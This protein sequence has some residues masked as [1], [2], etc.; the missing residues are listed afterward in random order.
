[1]KL[2][3]SGRLPSGAICNG[4]TRVLLAILAGARSHDDIAAACDMSR[5]SVH[6]AVHQLAD[7]A[8]VAIEAGRQGTLRALVEEVPVAA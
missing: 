8:L 3:P 5:G 6:Y 2:F 4:S 7:A 1:M